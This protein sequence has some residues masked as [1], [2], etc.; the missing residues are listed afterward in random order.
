MSRL[1][2]ITIAAFALV[3]S[4]DTADAKG[5]F[6]DS[7]CSCTLVT[8]DPS[9]PSKCVRPI[10]GIDGM[11]KE[12]PCKAGFKCDMLGTAMCSRSKCPSWVSVGS[13]AGAGNPNS[14]GAFKCAK[15]EKGADVE[16][17]KEDPSL[18][19]Q[20]TPVPT[21]VYNKDACT[22]VGFKSSD[23]CVKF[24]SILGGSSQCTLKSCSAGF[25]CD[26]LAPTHMCKRSLCTMFT[27]NKLDQD[28]PFPC[29]QSAAECAVVEKP[30][31]R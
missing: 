15:T 19:L 25:K 4:Y 9:A 14:S 13:E 6:T 24:D 1:F 5:V 17:I 20:A 2:A 12:E 22:C 10:E 7:A 28:A 26:C 18:R 27:A 21:C 11:C 31:K 8:P 16:C 23:M 3:A 29:L 30:L